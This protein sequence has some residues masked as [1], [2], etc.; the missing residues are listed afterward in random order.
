[1]AI[2]GAISN[3]RRKPAPNR[4]WRV[5]GLSRLSNGCLMNVL[6]KVDY[7]N[8]IAGLVAVILTLGI[9]YCAVANNS[10]PPATLAGAW[11][12]AVT[13]VFKNGSISPA[14][15]AQFR[16]VITGQDKAA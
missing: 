16:T 3:D 15:M 13:W 10:D 7:H 2:K 6:P 12:I 8:L 9:V 1:M 4:R 11:G 14:S 5:R